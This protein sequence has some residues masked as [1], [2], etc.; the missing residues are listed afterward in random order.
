VWTYLINFVP[1]CAILL[2]FFILGEP[3]TLSLL[4]GAA[5][6]ISGVSLTNMRS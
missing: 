1:V 2:A 6:V 3:V 5:F 4:V